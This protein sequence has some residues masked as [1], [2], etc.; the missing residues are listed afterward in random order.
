[1]ENNGKKENEN[2]ALFKQAINEAL[3][4]KFSKEIA[5][6]EGEIEVSESHKIQMNRIFRECTEGSFIPFP[7]IEENRP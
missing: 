6:T 3:D 1:M 2:L 7:E 5:L 4:R